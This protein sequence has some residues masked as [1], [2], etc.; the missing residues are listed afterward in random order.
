MNTN[1]NKPPRKTWLRARRAVQSTVLLAFVVAVLASGWGLFGFYSGHED[2]V[3]TPAD[4]PFFGTLSSSDVFGINLLDPFAVLQIAAASKS[5]V[6]DWLI[7]ALPIV[8]AYALIRGRAFCGWVCPVNLLLELTDALRRIF[9]IS[10]RERSIPRHTKLW[11]AGGIL[12]LSFATSVPLFEAFSPISAVN[13]GIVLG[14][15]AGLWT[16]ASIIVLE[17]FWS[18]R[19]WCRSLCP[20]GGFYEAIGRIGLLSVKIDH[21]A[22]IHCDACKQSCLAGPDIVVPVLADEAVC[23]RAGECMLCG[24]CIDSCPTRALSVTSP[25]VYG[26]SH[27]KR[28]QPAS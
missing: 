27:K 24:A 28:D 18:H 17:L 7:F 1:P 10:V 6:L 3:P 14:S 20:L 22:C 16:L 2:P 23:L 19:V 4:M 15:T 13:K 9:G 11:I 25:A 12:V 26:L 8:I 21:A 5:F